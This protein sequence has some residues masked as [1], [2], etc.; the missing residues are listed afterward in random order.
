VIAALA[1]R[2]RR[3]CAQV[4]GQTAD[5]YDL[6]RI[7]LRSA[8]KLGD[9]AQQNMTRWAVFTAASLLRKHAPEHKCARL[10]HAHLDISARHRQPLQ[11]GI[12][13]LRTVAAKTCVG[14]MHKDAKPIFV[15]LGQ[16]RRAKL[17]LVR[18]S[19]PES[20][21]AAHAQ[22]SDGCHGSGTGRGRLREGRRG[23]VISC[24][25]R[26]LRLSGE[27]STSAGHRPNPS[28]RCLLRQRSQAAW[29]SICTRVNALKVNAKA[30][31]CSHL[32]WHA[33]TD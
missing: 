17:G 23:G 30:G 4:I 33:M 13:C 10:L 9:A 20:A 27:D 22:G 32:S 8:N 26:N 2:L 21:C 3:R 15:P 1:F 29:S 5:L 24:L 14:V 16:S 6:Q 18:Y 12:F 11:C 31:R 19:H 7:L 25:L 28:A